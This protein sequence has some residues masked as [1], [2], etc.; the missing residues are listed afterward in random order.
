MTRTLR[1]TAFLSVFCLLAV[2]ALNGGSPP[3]S[4]DQHR[5]VTPGDLKWEQGFPAQAWR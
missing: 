4:N 2:L 1:W 3:A 5:L